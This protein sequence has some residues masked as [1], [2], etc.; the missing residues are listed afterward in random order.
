MTSTATT[1]APT[2][3]SSDWRANYAALPGAYDE[4]VTARGDIQSHWST[5][6]EHMDGLGSAEIARRWELALRMLHENGVSYNV[7]GD[8][9]GIDRPW[10]LDAVPMMVSAAN[11]AA[12]NVR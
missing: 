2:T 7:Y 5:F 1:A 3:V 8:P 6:V 9:H 10:V 12:S 4:M 11:G